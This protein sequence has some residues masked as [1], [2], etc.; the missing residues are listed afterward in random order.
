MLKTPP[1]I[2]PDS[3]EARRLEAHL[4]KI[5]IDFAALAR[6]PKFQAMLSE[7]DGGL[8]AVIDCMRYSEDPGI[9]AFL[10]R[11]DAGTDE[12]RE[13]IP[14][15]AW[16]VK[17]KLDI[18]KLLGAILFA[19]RQQ[20][21]QIVKILAISNHPATVRAQIEQAKRPE[22]FK[23]RNA[24][25]VALGFAPSAKGPANIGNSF[26]AGIVEEEPEETD[27]NMPGDVDV[28]DLFPDISQTQRLL[29]E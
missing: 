24:L 26:A 13:I 10:K 14:W 8:P 20:S 15:E 7:A 12:D 11:Y 25:N 4:I 17:A 29:N 6:A 19:L 2:N 5:D 16:A 22:G 28:E 9:I 21:V 3:P 18:S 27:T 1:K 23:D